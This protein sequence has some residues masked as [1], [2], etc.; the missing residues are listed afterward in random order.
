MHL[1]LFE[2]VPTMHLQQR[3]KKL[4]IDVGCIVHRFLVLS[5]Y[6]E[7]LVRCQWFRNLLFTR[8]FIYFQMELTH[9][10]KL[11]SSQEDEDRA[12]TYDGISNH[13]T[14]DCCLVRFSAT[15]C[16]FVSIIL[17]TD[18]DTGKVFKSHIHNLPS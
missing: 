4:R 9:S 17:S 15:S 1:G 18:E 11:E 10:K 6:G 14:F 16:M 2:D 13:F 12:V 5:F 7:D 3:K 8:G